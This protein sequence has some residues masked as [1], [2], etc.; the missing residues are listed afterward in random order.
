MARAWFSLSIA[1][2]LLL[3]ECLFAQQSFPSPLIEIHDTEF[4]VSSPP[5]Q[6]ATGNIRVS[7][8]KIVVLN[9]R[10]FLLGSTLTRIN[11]LA[12][13]H[14]GK[15]L[16]AGKE[17]GRL[18]VWD[19][20]SQKIIC[21]IDTGFDGVGR[22]AISPDNQFIAAASA[23]WVPGIKL[24]HIPDGQL[25]NALEDTHANVG[26]LL[27]TLNPNLLIVSSGLFA[28]PL[29]GAHANGGQPLNSPHPNP[30]IVPSGSTDVF[31]TASGK[32]V[33][34]FASEMDSVLSN[35]GSTLLTVKGSE[36]VLRNTRDWTVERTL[37]RL[38]N[39]ERPVFLDA[40]RGLFLFEDRTDDHLFVAARTSDGQMLPDERLANL[41]KSWLDSSE[42][43][44][45]DPNTGLVFGHSAGQLWALDM[46]TGKTCLSPQLISDGA[47][48][49]PDGNLLAG[50]FD[51][52]TPTENQ[53]HAG[54]E[55]WKTGALAKVCH[56]Q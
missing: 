40:A 43:A 20:A 7:T 12:F 8:D 27:Y 42:F 18:V 55:I 10:S 6:G 35:D 54:V 9:G 1:I 28:N 19:V 15:L 29:E 32:L 45:F 51:S 46:K 33:R 24:W 3:P 4:K 16:A 30:P 21:V 5:S 38:T 53:K 48:L 11:S 41:P 2:C 47:A 39:Y 31:D 14:D 34:S 26:H 52:E 36:I 37:P 56:L 44:A 25:A 22:V 17:H 23:A 49:S 50:A 13:S